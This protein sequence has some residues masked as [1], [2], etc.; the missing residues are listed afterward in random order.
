[1]SGNKASAA[2]SNTGRV[3][4]VLS[5]TVEERLPLEAGGQQIEIGPVFV[6]RSS[7]DDRVVAL[8]RPEEAGTMLKI[9]QLGSLALTH[10]PHDVLA[11][12]IRAKAVLVAEEAEAE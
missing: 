9:M 2:Q 3:A 1:L 7:R 5:L 10:V 4:E 6:V 8:G 12:E 11:A